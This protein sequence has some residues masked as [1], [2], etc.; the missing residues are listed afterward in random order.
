MFEEELDSGHWVALLKYEDTVEFFD[1]YGKKWD[2]E[3]SWIPR[4]RREKLGETQKYLSGLLER[5]NLKRIYNPYHFE[6]MQNTVNTCGHH[7]AHRIYR[8]KHNNLDLHDYWVYMEDAREKFKAN[9]DE[10]VAEF[11]ESFG[12]SMKTYLNIYLI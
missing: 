1:P 4:E 7:S 2:S 3:L 9:Y 8:L 5:S 10:V 11:V 12:I 6:A